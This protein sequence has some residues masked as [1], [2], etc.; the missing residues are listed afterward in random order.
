M[1]TYYFGRLQRDDPRSAAQL[2]WADQ[3]GD[4]THVNI[5]G[6]GVTRM[7]RVQRQAQKFLEWLSQPEA[8][9]MFAGV[10]LE[11]PAIAR[12][13]GRSAQVAA[14]GEFKP[15]PLNVAQCR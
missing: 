1:N 12:G 11:Y 10:D 8:Q 7:R 6:A 3:R 14:W 13:Q 5:S 9:A 2:F 15:S 4:G